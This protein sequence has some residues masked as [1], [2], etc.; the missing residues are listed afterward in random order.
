MTFAVIR[1][2]G[3]QYRVTPNAVLTVEK[4]EAEPGATITFHDVLAVGGEAGLTLG[5]PTVP[6]ATVTATVVEQTRG[7]KV[8]IFK[9]KRRQN[10]RRKRGHRQDLTVVRI[11]DIAAA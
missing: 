3:K 5:A 7:D 6:G 8:I 10:Y 1:T 4:L 9:K 2:G 11:A